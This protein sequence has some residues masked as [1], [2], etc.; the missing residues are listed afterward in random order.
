VRIDVLT[1]SVPKR[2]RML[3]ECVESIRNQ[4]LR[5]AAH[6]VGVDYERT[7]VVNMLNR[8]FACSDAEWVLPIADDDI[9]YPD[10]LETLAAAV[11]NSVDVVYSFC[12]VEGAGWSTNSLFDEERLRNEN[13]IPSTALVRA[14]AI[15]RVG[16]W[17]HT[18]LGFEDW[19]LWLDILNSG[20]GFRCVPERKWLYRIHGDNLS[21][22]GLKDIL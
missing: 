5:P 7:G 9:A 10:L 14:S 2:S 20:G 1:P 22:G 16:G 12:D 15:R 4:T 21:R 17:K 13:Y 18:K 11:D 8:L 19:Q 3:A 6:L